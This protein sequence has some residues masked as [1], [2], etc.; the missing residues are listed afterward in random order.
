VKRTVCAVALIAAVISSCAEPRQLGV[1][2]VNDTGLCSRLVVASR[3]Q[4]AD[5]PPCELGRGRPLQ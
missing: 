4:G 5:D 3:V 2:T 1:L